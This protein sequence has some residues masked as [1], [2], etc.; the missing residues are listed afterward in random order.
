MWYNEL[1]SK[2]INLKP[3][4]EI[5]VEAGKV[6][7]PKSNSRFFLHWYNDKGKMVASHQIKHAT[8]VNNTAKLINPENFD[9]VILQIDIPNS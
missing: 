8:L 3:K 6:L 5:Q 2:L 9:A 1:K 4:E 7:V